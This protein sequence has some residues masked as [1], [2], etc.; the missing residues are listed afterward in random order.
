MEGWQTREETL[1]I[2]LLGAWVHLGVA[3]SDFLGARIWPDSHPSS[4][5][6]P[7]RYVGLVCKLVQKSNSLE[8]KLNE[9]A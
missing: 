5:P 4:K 3:D 9:L 1:R 7:Q 2:L 8:I 6:T